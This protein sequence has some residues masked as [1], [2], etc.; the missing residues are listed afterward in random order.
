MVMYTPHHDNNVYTHIHT[1]GDSIGE[2]VEFYT[3]RRV[4]PLGDMFN[5]LENPCWL[6]PLADSPLTLHPKM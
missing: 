5:Q 3:Q 2:D 6:G 1:P 4:P